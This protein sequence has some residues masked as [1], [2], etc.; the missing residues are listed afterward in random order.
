MNILKKILFIVSSIISLQGFSQSTT[1]TLNTTTGIDD[2]MVVGAGLVNTN[3]GTQ[4]TMGVFRDD[5]VTPIISRSFI[6]FDLSSIPANAIITSATLKLTTSSVTSSPTSY[7][8]IVERVDIDDY[9][10]GNNWDEATITWNNQPAVISSDAITVYSSGASPEQST[11]NGTQE[12]DVKLHVQNMVNYS[13]NNHGWGIRLSDETVSGNDYGVYFHTS[14]ATSNKPELEVTYVLPL[15][16]ESTVTHCTSGSNNGSVDLTVS[17]GSGTYSRLVLYRIDKN[18]SYTAREVVNTISTHTT[19][20]NTLIDETNN[21]QPGLYRVYLRDALW[22]GNNAYDNAH[23]VENFHFLVGQ[24]GTSICAVLVNTYKVED[25]QIGKN[26]GAFASSNDYAN[27]NY[28]G[29][30]DQLGISHS[31][32]DK[33]GAQQVN[34]YMYAS[35]VD[36]KMDVSPDLDI[37]QADLHLYGWTRYYQTYNSSNEAAYTIVTEPWN[38]DIVTWNC[39]PATNPA[40]QVISP[41]TSV[42]NGYTNDRNDQIDI[43]P[44]MQYWQS[45]PN[46]GLEMAL[47]SYNHTEFSSRSQKSLS[48][49]IGY[50]EICFDVKSASDEAYVGLKRQMTGGYYEVPVDDVLRV[51]YTEEYLDNDNNL[52]FKILNNAGFEQTVTGQLITHGDNRIDLDVSALSTGFYILEINNDKNEIFYLRFKVV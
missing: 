23:F 38:D 2:A 18:V 41:K 42:V 35:L 51:K 17:G 7:D 14:E 13:Y 19:V 3:Y 44:L 10:N 26:I 12:V 28:K 31:G 37:Q 16:I 21:L 6:R 34:A 30:T 43:L 29:V 50:L 4:T 52:N 9:V 24:V 11:Y 40:Y 48:N 33:I 22:T 36:F 39:R 46:Y 1:V 25:I 49:D 20:N 15:Q 45:N 27:I 32:T 8:Y 47:S 5:Q